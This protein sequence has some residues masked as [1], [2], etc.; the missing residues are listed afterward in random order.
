[1]AFK[2]KYSDEDLLNIIKN[3]ASSL[4]RAPYKREIKNSPTICNRFG[5]WN[6]A[7]KIAGLT[8]NKKSYINKDSLPGTKFN[9]LTVLEFLYNKNGKSYWKCRCICGKHTII[10]RANLIK[11]KSCGCRLTTNKFRGTYDKR[12]AQAYYNMIKRCTDKNNKSYKNYGGRGISV[13]DKWL[14]L[15]GFLED[16]LASY[17]SGLTLDRIDVDGNYNKDNCRWATNKVQSNNKTN[18]VYNEYYGD[19][20]TISEICDKTG[21]NYSLIRDRLSQGLS[22]YEALEKPVFE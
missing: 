20:L 19:Y 4:G 21:I 12:I 6:N 3:K 14:I 9:E 13:C 17:H 10:Q 2:K 1:M 18:N 22:I 7:I 8:P 15:E 16:M 5:T 11:T